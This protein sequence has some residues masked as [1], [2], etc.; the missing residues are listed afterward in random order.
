MVRF[1]K[2]V[3]FDKAGFT[4]A[5][6]EFSRSSFREFV[7]FTGARFT[8]GAMF[9]HTVFHSDA[10]F[11]RTEFDGVAAFN[12]ACFRRRVTFQEAA[13]TGPATF[14]DAQFSGAELSVPATDEDYEPRVSWSAPLPAAFAFLEGSVD[15]QRAQ[16]R[17]PVVRF[18]KARFGRPASYVRTQFACSVTFADTAFVHRQSFALTRFEGADPIG[19]DDATRRRPPQL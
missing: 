3:R 10:D 13:F 12:K 7:V 4:D 14:E 11:S 6:A 19:L 15:R 2:A 1:E 5:A 8:G 9:D 18:D 16:T 17:Q